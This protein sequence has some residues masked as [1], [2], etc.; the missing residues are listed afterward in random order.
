MPDNA[1]AKPP[2]AREE[3]LRDMWELQ[4][5]SIVRALSSGD[6]SAAVMNVARAFLSDNGTSID[7]LRHWR[8]GGAAAV[9][10]LPFPDAGSDGGDALHTDTPFVQPVD[11]DE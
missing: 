1:P 11:P 5:D 7:S 8:L 2:K 3:I 6:P 4:A 10:P 9:G